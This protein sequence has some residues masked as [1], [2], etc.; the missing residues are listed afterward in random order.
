MLNSQE[1]VLL[2]ARVPAYIKERLSK[3]CLSHG[4]KM[5]YF[6]SE[7]IKERLLEIAEDSRD[8]AVAQGRLKAPEF[9]SQKEFDKYLLKRGIKS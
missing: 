7:A 1:Q 2:G 3:Y 6:I 9:I 5:N 4:I 8:I